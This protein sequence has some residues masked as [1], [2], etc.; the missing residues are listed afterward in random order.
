MEK[1]MTRDRSV[2]EHYDAAAETYHRQYERDV[3]FDTTVEYPANYFRLQLLINSFVEKQLQRVV[4]VGV[5]EGTPL[6][7]LAKT[8]VDVW[9]FDIS[10][11]MVKKAKE[12][13][14]RAG[15]DAD[16]IFWGDIEDPTTYA[17]ALRDGQFDGV[18]AMGV[19][20]HVS[21]DESALRNMA[22]LIRPGGTAFIEF[23]NTLFSLFTFNR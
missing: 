23:R 2:R 4:E 12:T 7:T 19:M 17:H 6:L 5:G 16:H 11:E 9:G 3:I 20:P 15:I 1:R 13:V 22:A 10:P 18:M 8:G 14:G 21:N